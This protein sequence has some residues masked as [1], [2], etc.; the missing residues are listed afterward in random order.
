MQ[1][2]TLNESALF[3]KLRNGISRSDTTLLFYMDADNRI[4]AYCK[5]H[6]YIDKDEFNSLDFFGEFDNLA[7]FLACFPIDSPDE[8]FKVDPLHFLDLFDKGLIDL[9]CYVENNGNGRRFFFHKCNNQLF[10]MEENKSEQFEIKQII[11]SG[12]GFVRYAA[13]FA[14]HYR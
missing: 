2:S 14:K 7:K 6:G 9:S 10:I 11:K 5:H 4:F 3:S 8:L 13:D 12:Y 1:V